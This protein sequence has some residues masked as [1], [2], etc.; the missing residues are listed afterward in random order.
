MREMTREELRKCQIAILNYFH[1]LCVHNN[2]CYWLDYGT[3]L[4]AVRHK[5][6]IPWDDDIDVAMLRKDYD[7]LIKV[8]CQDSNS[9]YKLSC[10]ENDPACMY[11]FGK[12]ID[13][14]TVLYELGEN[15]IKTGVYIDVFVYDDVPENENE[16]NKVFDKLDFYGNLRK[17]QLPMK[18]A[19]L[20]FKRMLVIIVRVIISFFPKQYFTKKIVE[21][22]RNYSYLHTNYVSDITC[23]YYYTR[24]CVNKAI[25]EE[26]IEL[27]FE[28]HFYKAPKRY[29]E[30][31]SLQ[32]NDYM[33]IPPIEEQQAAQHKIKAYSK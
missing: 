9:R 11:P 19:P 26:L 4:G 18:K 25:F 12:I 3:L 14:Q 20:S 7:K 1:N 29:D 13:T 32:Y 23:P 5:G 28:K 8:C 24:W 17:Y 30:W 2:L 22:A 16:R 27:E 10:V 15:G 6:F 21:N 33:K 31:L